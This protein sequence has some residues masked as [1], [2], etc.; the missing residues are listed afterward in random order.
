MT[1][2]VGSQSR[3]IQEVAKT[4]LNNTLYLT[5]K[6]T[7]VIP[8]ESD[9]LAED[10][11]DAV[12]KSLDSGGSLASSGTINIANSSLDS[13]VNI[14]SSYSGTP[15]KSI[16][17]GSNTD[18][19][20]TSIS[21]KTI[22]IG[23]TTCDI[24]STTLEISGTDLSIDT[25]TANISSLTSMDISTD[26]SFSLSSSVINCSSTSTEINS[27]SISLGNQSNTTTATLA[28]ASGY[29]DLSST[30]TNML[31]SQPITIG[32]S[33]TTSI[34]GSDTGL[35][36]AGSRTC[37][38]LSSSSATLAKKET[39]GGTT[40]DGAYALCGSS[41]ASLATID[42]STG[43][44]ISRSYI[45]LTKS[46][47][48]T[49]SAELYGQNKVVLHTIDSD[50]TVE[51]SSLTLGRTTGTTLESRYAITN[52]CGATIT[53]IG[54]NSSMQDSSSRSYTEVGYF[55][56]AYDTH[57]TGNDDLGATGNYLGF[58][59]SMKVTNTSNV[60]TAEAGI[61]DTLGLFPA[62]TIPADRKFYSTFGFYSKH[63][64]APFTGVHIYG[65][66]ENQAIQ[67]GDCVYIDSNRLCGVVTTKEY[68][69]CCG[70]A[71]A[72]HSSHVEVAAV[73]DTECGNCYGFKVTN[74]NGDIRAGDLLVTSS[75]PGYLMRQSD[76]I[77]RSYTVGKSAQDVSFDSEGKATDVYGYIYCG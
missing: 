23:G 20:T 54:S 74:E 41:N 76:D 66:Q 36:S 15:E 45:T 25:S 52:R 57:I 51:G 14:A 32:S 31:A 12:Q 44:A 39:F 75:T 28:C 2:L 42:T 60:I 53:T 11:G 56:P 43:S 73:G 9:N 33:G 18:Y 65:L 1:I 35:D 24:S 50:L 19:N 62:L 55:S 40:V 13:E 71:I 47:T 64:I 3:T 68:R 38:T 58:G 29:I 69:M 22:S 30:Y 5:T 49:T 6:E 26:G 59:M 77:I 4:K 70:I 27:D 10:S 67:V 72:V 17:I 63:G 48:A 61:L 16:T 46:N 21:S 8:V 37:L 7:V 34:N